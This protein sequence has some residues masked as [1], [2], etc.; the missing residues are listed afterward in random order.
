M[1]LLENSSLHLIVYQIEIRA[2][3]GEG[4][5]HASKYLRDVNESTERAPVIPES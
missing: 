3:K 2:R 4:A 5:L 1:R